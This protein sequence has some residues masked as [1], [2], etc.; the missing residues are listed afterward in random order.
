MKMKAEIRVT[1][2]QFKDQSSTCKPPEARRQAWNRFFLT[3]LRRSQHFDLE[4]LAS[5]P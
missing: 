3:A 5:R 2:L 1:H 4:L